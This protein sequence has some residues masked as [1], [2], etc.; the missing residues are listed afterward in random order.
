MDGKGSPRGIGR[1]GTQRAAG[2]PVRG[3]ARSGNGAFAA[4]D[5]LATFPVDLR[6]GFDGLAAVTREVLQQD[7]LPGHL[8]AFR[9]RLRGSIGAELF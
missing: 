5:F 7:P 3:G 2:G 8:F 4:L 6:R 1:A 9:N